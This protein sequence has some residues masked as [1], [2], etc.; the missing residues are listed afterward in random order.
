MILTLSLLTHTFSLYLL[1]FSCSIG[2]YGSAQIARQRC[3]DF[4]EQQNEEFEKQTKDS[5]HS[6]SSKRTSST[7]LSDR[8]DRTTIV[9]LVD[10]MD[11][12]ITTDEGVV[13]NFFNWAM[14]PGSGLLLVGMTLSTI[15]FLHFPTH[16]HTILHSPNSSTSYTTTYYNLLQSSSLSHLPTLITLLPPSLIL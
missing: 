3:Q 7:S 12:L 10:E 6:H 16:F 11:F 14:L 4:F 15:L 2:N 8:T 9:C 13:Y 1:T 5:N